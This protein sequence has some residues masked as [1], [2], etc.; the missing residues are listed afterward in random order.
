MDRGQQRAENQTRPAAETRTHRVHVPRTEDGRALVLQPEAVHGVAWSSCGTMA[1][2]LSHAN[3][4]F[5]L[6]DIQAHELFATCEISEGTGPKGPGC[7]PGFEAMPTLLELSFIRCEGQRKNA[8]TLMPTD[9]FGSYIEPINVRDAPFGKPFRTTLAITLKKSIKLCGTFVLTIGSG[10]Q[11]GFYIAAIGAPLM[12]GVRGY[13][14]ANPDNIKGADRKQMLR[15][16]FAYEI[17]FTD[18][19]CGPDGANFP[20]RGEGDKG[21]VMLNPYTDCITTWDPFPTCLVTYAEATD[22]YGMLDKVETPTRH[23]ATP[24][25]C[26]K[27]GSG[28][29][30]ELGFVYLRAEE[31]MATPVQNP[32]PNKPDNVAFFN[33]MMVTLPCTIE[34]DD[35]DMGRKGSPAVLFVTESP[36][37]PSDFGF[38]EYVRLSD[39]SQ[40]K[41]W[42]LCKDVPS[43]IESKWGDFTFNGRVIH[44]GKANVPPAMGLRE[45]TPKEKAELERL[46]KENEKLRDNQEQAAKKFADAAAHFENQVET[47][48]DDIKAASKTLRTLNTEWRRFVNKVGKKPMEI[49]DDNVRI[50]FFN[51]RD[52]INEAQTKVSTLQNMRSKLISDQAIEDIESAKGFLDC[53]F[54]AADTD[55]AGPASK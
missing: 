8:L 55:E 3:G 53:D 7:C 17:E 30:E 33:I 13:A 49:K 50:E 32:E 43:F 5:E 44:A 23:T 28:G 4:Q 22:K 29:Q 24:F 16:N 9:T 38:Q 36:R 45:A 40:T 2:V 42:Y 19:I 47:I 25:W 48:D 34:T 41:F 11:Q 14:F 46:N 54:T 26:P 52:A 51:K 1:I 21:I 37:D 31:A 15:N 27:V 10:G 18:G 20:K 35:G 6:D 39:S 12:K